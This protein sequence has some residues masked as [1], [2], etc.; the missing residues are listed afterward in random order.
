VKENM[1]INII[2]PPALT[3]SRDRKIQI[4]PERGRVQQLKGWLACDF[5]GSV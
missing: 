3:Y 1:Y 2:P 4:H 5:H